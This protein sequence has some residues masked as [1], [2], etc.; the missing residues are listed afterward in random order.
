MNPNNVTGLAAGQY[1]ESQVFQRA[2]FSYINY[3]LRA[4]CCKAGNNIANTANRYYIYTERR[5]P[6]GNKA[7]HVVV[8]GTNHDWTAQLSVSVMCDHGLDSIR[9]R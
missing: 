5:E 1:W 2:I 8:L 9:H 4:V 6:S 3:F 7:Y